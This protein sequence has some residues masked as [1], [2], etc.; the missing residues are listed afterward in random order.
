MV[1]TAPKSLVGENPQS[2]RPRGLHIV[3][4]AAKA[5]RLIHSVTRPFPTQPTSLGL[6]GVPFDAEFFCGCAPFRRLFDLG[7][8]GNQFADLIVNGIHPLP[9]FFHILSVDISGCVYFLR[10]LI[11][12][13]IGVTR[14]IKAG[15]RFSLKT[16]KFLPGLGISVSSKERNSTPSLSRTS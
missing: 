3:R 5:A 14:P 1:P 8:L 11:D 7:N 9:D 2:P 15:L 13:V 4:L 10:N 16:G 12:V 6:R